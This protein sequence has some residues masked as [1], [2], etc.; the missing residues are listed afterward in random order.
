[1]SLPANIQ[2]QATA[3]EEQDIMLDGEKI[4][5]IKFHP[6]LRKQY[7]AVLPISY[8]FRGT[9]DAAIPIWGY[10]EDMAAAIND[11]M[12]KGI[13]HHSQVIQGIITLSKRLQ[14][15]DAA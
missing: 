12:E 1:M 14:A 4:G 11:A 13:D 6:G 9:A 15:E 3:A 10:G 8:S 2:V 5:T 7:Q